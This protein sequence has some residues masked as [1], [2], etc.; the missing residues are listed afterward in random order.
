MKIILEKPYSHHYSPTR[1]L[2]NKEFIMC[3]G[4]FPDPNDRSLNE[5]AILLSPRRVLELYNQDMSIL[6]NPV[7]NQKKKKLMMMF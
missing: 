6:T 1:L 3:Q 4:V 7:M 5:P 2:T